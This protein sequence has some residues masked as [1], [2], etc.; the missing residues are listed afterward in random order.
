MSPGSFVGVILEGT[1]LSAL[2]A[3]ARFVGVALQPDFDV[4][5]FEIKV[6]GLDQPVCFETEQQGVMLIEIVHAAMLVKASVKSQLQRR[7]P[8]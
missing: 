1:S 5:C 6:D 7:Q 3:T 8:R 2:G 4:L